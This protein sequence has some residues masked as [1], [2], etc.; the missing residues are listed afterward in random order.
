MADRCSGAKAW[1]KSEYTAALLLSLLE[2]VIEI[3]P[4]F[5]SADITSSI[6]W[7]ETLTLPDRRSKKGYS[8]SQ[9]LIFYGFRHTFIFDCR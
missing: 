3:S 9:H 6:S 5:L 1:D 8:A 4:S 2:C 7:N